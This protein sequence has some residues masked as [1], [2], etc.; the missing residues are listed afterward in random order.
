MTC[1]PACLSAC[2]S[3]HLSVCPDVELEQI[4]FIDS[5][6]GEEEE[7][8]GRRGGGRD[9]VSLS[10]QFMAYIERRITREV[11]PTRAHGHTCLLF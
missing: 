1:L 7:D 9:S 10:S 4:D 2:L 6:V 5:C 11:R 3:L 8:E